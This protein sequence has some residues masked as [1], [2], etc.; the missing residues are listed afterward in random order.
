MK[1]HMQN[2]SSYSEGFIK[3]R[4]KYQKDK[5]RDYKGVAW[6]GPAHQLCKDVAF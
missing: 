2:L 6:S 3:G 5:E 1:L 4:D